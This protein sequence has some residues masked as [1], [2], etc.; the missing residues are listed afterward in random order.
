[1]FLIVPIFVWNVPLVSLILLKRMLIFPIILF[2]S[3]SWHCSLKKAFLSLLS[4]WSSAFSW[5]Y[6]SFLLLLLPFSGIYCLSFHV[7]QVFIVFPF[8][9]LLFSGICKTSSDNYLSFLLFFPQVFVRP[10]QTTILP[11][12]IS[13]SW[14]W[15]WSL[16]PI[17]CSEPPSIVLQALCLPDLIPWIY[18]SLPLSNHKVFDLGHTWMAYRFS[19]LSSI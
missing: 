16:L 15:F 1:M 17:Q 11:S 4:I 9:S 6:I 3:V 18:L 5:A 13:F 12:C 10:P 14:G 8:M 2:S 7:F 19:L